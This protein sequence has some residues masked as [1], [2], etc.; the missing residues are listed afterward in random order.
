[1]E[2]H[3]EEKKTPNQKDI[4]S[5]YIQFHKKTLLKIVSLIVHRKNYN[6]KVKKNNTSK[7]NFHKK[8]SER[9]C[10]WGTKEGY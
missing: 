8:L 6:M 7:K 10:Q 3:R 5:L 1:M 4:I 9:S 2:V